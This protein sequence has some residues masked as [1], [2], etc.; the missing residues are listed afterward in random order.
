MR[1]RTAVA[2]ALAFV[3]SAAVAAPAAA[4]S[5]DGLRTYVVDGVRTSLDRAAVAGSGAA[6]VEA[7]HGSVVVSASP[8]DARRLR[9]LRYRVRLGVLVR[10]AA[11]HAVTQLT[12]PARVAGRRRHDH[13]AVVGLDDRGA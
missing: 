13:R 8:S 10:G 1:A 4:R 5:N 2:A 11:A 3:C 12:Q 7:D 6:I 9:Q